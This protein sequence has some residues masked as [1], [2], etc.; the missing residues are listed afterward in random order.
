MI[1]GKT[2]LYTAFTLMIMIALHISIV[3]LTEVRKGGG[4]ISAMFTGKSIKETAY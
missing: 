1:F 3:I 2:H 4:L